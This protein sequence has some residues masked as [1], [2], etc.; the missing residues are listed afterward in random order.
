[1]EGLIGQLGGELTYSDN[2]PGL[3][4]R[5]KIPIKHRRRWAAME[6]NT[7]RESV[8]RISLKEEWHGVS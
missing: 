7:I 5:I 4:T 3:H 8:C 6:G 1:M 2:Y